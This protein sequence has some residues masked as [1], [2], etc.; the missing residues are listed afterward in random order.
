MHKFTPILERVKGKKEDYATYGFKKIEMAALNTFFDLAQEYSSLEKLYMVSV[1]VPRVFFGLPCNLYLIDPKN[2]AIKWVAN[3]D[4]GLCKTETEVPHYIKITDTPYRYGPAYVVPIH[5]KKTP[6]SRI[7]YYCSGDVIGIFEVTESDDL[8]EAELFFIQKYVNRIGYNLYN[9][10]LA[11]QNIQHLKFI[12]NLVADVEHNVIAP[13]LHYKYYFRKIRKYLNRNKEIESEVDKLLSEVKSTNPKVYAK[14]SEILEEMVVIN[15]SMFNDQEKIERHYKHTSL[16]LETLFRPDHFLFGEYIVKRTPCH[17]WGDIILPQLERYRDRFAQQGIMVDHIIKRYKA[18]EDL[19]VRVDRGLLA[20]VVVNLLSNAAKYTESIA[21]ASG[22]KVKRV[23]CSTLLLKHFFG[24]GHHGARF[25]VFT[26]GEPIDP[27][28]AAHIFD[29]GVRL[30]QR[31]PVE[32]KGH[33]LYFV[34]N[35]VEVHGGVVGHKAER[36][37]NYFYFIIPT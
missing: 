4:F 25:D 18:S 9:K 2:E 33:G 30:T 20:Q 13:N 24:R 23:E 36:H 17:L 34:K 8:T 28:T 12:N 26:T 37:G 7:L 31:D 21:D 29:E 27:E 19:Q 15:R 5:G 32:G 11:E 1:A 35:V 3:S 14:I 10:Y 16:F 6:A 22:K